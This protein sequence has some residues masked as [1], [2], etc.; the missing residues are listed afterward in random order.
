MMARLYL[1]SVLMLVYFWPGYL[2]SPI[3]LGVRFSKSTGG[4][5]E[6]GSSGTTSQTSDG[7]LALAETMPWTL[8]VGTPLQFEAEPGII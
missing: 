4:R 2:A 8:G 7:S 5:R 1:I 3:A 6:N